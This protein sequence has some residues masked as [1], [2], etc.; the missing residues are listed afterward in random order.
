MSSQTA[1]S[2]TP[3]LNV[4]VSRDPATDQLLETYA[5]HKPDEVESLL[6]ENNAAFR[7]WRA[8][9]MSGRVA[10]YRRLSAILRERSESLAAIIT[11]EM[12]KPLPLRVQK[13]RSVQ[14]RLT[15]LPVMVQLSSLMNR[16]L[17]KMT[18]R[19]TSLICRLAQFWQ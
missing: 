18:T 11:A 13:L 16:W 1:T 17:V 15:G 5:F 9:P 19:C 14:P 3:V 7:L 6:S 4:A 2:T 8:T 12:G 10:A